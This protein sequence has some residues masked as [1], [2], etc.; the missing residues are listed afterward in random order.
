M[1]LQNI[2]MGFVVFVFLY[3][4]YSSSK[5]AKQILCI[6]RRVDKTRIEKWVSRHS[7]FV[8]FDG[9][10]YQIEPDRIG[11]Q[12]YTR[13]IHLF[14]PIWVQAL[15]Y[16]WYSKHPH[17]PNNWDNNSESP[18]VN[19]ALNMEQ[20]TKDIAKGLATQSGGKKENMLQKYLPYILLIGFAIIG[21]MYYTQKLQID[22]IIKTLQGG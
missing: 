13:D 21:V 5:K 8:L 7:D 18:G 16:S 2:I 22:A 3:A 19:E 12:M 10:K 20:A 11:L 14:L 4:W 17:D 6:Y 15:D 9:A 1:N